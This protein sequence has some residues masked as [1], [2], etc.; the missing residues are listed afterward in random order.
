MCEA[1]DGN[2]RSGIESFTLSCLISVLKCDPIGEAA[3]GACHRTG[4]S[5]GLAGAKSKPKIEE[6]CKKMKKVEKNA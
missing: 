6:N 1:D 5:I 4:R 3:R 2:T